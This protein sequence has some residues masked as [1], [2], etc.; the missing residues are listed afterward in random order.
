MDEVGTSVDSTGD[1]K[2]GVCESND[3]A[4]DSNDGS[5]AGLVGSWNE[6]SSNSSSLKAAVCSGSNRDFHE[7]SS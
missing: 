1:P 2:G 5:G 7:V 3:G 6:V 4:G